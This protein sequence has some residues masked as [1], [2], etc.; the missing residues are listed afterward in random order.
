MEY[1]FSQYTTAGQV[2][3]V[4]NKGMDDFHGKIN[5]YEK[6]IKG[7]KKVYSFDVVTGKAGIVE[8][9]KKREG[10]NATPAGVYTLGFVFGYHNR[11]ETKM[12]YTELTDN[13][14]WVDDPEHPMYNRFIRGDIDAKS[15]EK[16]KRDDNLYKLGVVINYNTNPVVKYRGSA[17]FMHIW[18]DPDTP[19]SGCIALSEDDI[20]KIISWL[21]PEKNPIIIIKGKI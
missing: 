9:E 6:S 15:F 20:K 1:E 4:E 16:M 11:P 18:K 7:W 17:I 12:A 3:I 5:C 13:D 19:T 21:D 2:I 14:K 10:D 8:G